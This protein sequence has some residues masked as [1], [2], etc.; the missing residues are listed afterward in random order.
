MPIDRH[1]LVLAHDREVHQFLSRIPQLEQERAGEPANIEV[2]Q[3][4]GGEG[5]DAG[6]QPVAVGIGIALDVPTGAEGD[7][8]AKEGGA[9]HAQPVRQLSQ[10]QPLVG[11]GVRQCFQHSQPLVEGAQHE[12]CGRLRCRH[13]LHPAVSPGRMTV[14]ELSV[15]FGC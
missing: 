6:A 5:Q 3:Q 8:E 9:V 10:R 15:V 14:P 1:Y 13:Q 4:R 7:E 11:I 12:R 2:V